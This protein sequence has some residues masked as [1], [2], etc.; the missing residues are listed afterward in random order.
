MK[1]INRIFALVVLVA[2]A[3]AGPALGASYDELNLG[4]QLLNQGAPDQAIPHFDQ[5]IAAGDLIP[6]LTAVAHLDRAYAYKNLDQPVKA[7]DD[8]TA[9]LSYAPDDLRVRF[10]RSLA[11]GNAGDAPKAMADI[12]AV[13]EK[14]PKAAQF[15][16]VIGLLDWQLRQ[17]AEASGSFSRALAS[18]KDHAYAWL[19][20]QLANVKLG[21]PVSAEG[22]A[23][24]DRNAWPAPLVSF[25]QGK[26][27]RDEVFDIAAQAKGADG[28]GKICE[29]NFYLGEW[30]VV[31]DSPSDAK[32]LIQKAAENCPRTFLERNMGR[33]EIAKWP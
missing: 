30:Q 22:A 12:A 1:L 10:E 13:K 5:A 2:A 8:F 26:V 6:D 16:F 11:Y 21:K 23:S 24:F 29:A 32:T 31:H 19:W 17:Y 14:F 4:I 15:D 27:T 7:V 18:P 20:L 25:F 28:P 33:Q 9:Y 3:S